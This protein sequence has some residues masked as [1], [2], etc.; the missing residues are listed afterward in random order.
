MNKIK[1][2]TPIHYEVYGD[3]ETLV[4]F[5]PLATDHRAMKA[6][7]EP[8]FEGITGWQ[9]IYVDLP[10]HGHSEVSPDV[11]TS[12]D[13][14]EIIVNF[15]TSLL[16]ETRRFSL[17][18]MSFGGYIAQ[19]IFSRMNHRIDGLC[20]LVPPINKEVRTLPERV[21]LAKE[22]NL[23][24]G[25][26]DDIAT[27]FDTLLVVQNKRNLSAF[28]AEIQPGRELANREFLSGEWRKTGYYYSQQP[29]REGEVFSN[30]TLILVGRHDW[31]CG[32]ED[33]WSLLKH[34]PRA[35]F[36]VLDD[37]GHLIPIE[38]RSLVQT[39]F[40][41]WLERVCLIQ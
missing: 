6:W 33:Q 37:A 35:T 34:F 38:K 11:R 18:G 3:G 5:H 28:L 21:V 22:E 17:V 19:G 23:L 26:G 25:I 1:I 2:D 36:A 41:E 15:L 7:M 16:G 14:V 31:I 29:F 24:R 8:L 39:L 4:I 9:R 13:I 27:A 32:Y 12:D 20:L 40:V 30:P 10:A